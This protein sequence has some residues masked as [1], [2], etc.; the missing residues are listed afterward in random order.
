MPNKIKKSNIFVFFP[1]KFLLKK[2]F[3]LITLSP[4]W[5]ISGEKWSSGVVAKSKNAKMETSHAIKNVFYG[6]F[7]SH[8]LSKSTEFLGCFG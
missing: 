4:N 6:L 7:R 1:K 8:F 2:S 5:G 3:P